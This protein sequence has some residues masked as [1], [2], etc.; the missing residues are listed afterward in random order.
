MGNPGV[1][2]MDDEDVERIL[3]SMEHIY[4]KPNME[5]ASRYTRFRQVI[6]RGYLYGT[7]TE[8]QK[9]IERAKADNRKIP[10]T[11]F[12]WAQYEPLSEGIQDRYSE[13]EVK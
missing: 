8:M 10:R 2:H 9:R 4:G 13:E 11:T 5:L 1:S 12:S 6:I 3:N 7:Q